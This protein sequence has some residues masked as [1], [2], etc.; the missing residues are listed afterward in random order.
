[1]GVDASEVPR[2]YFQVVPFGNTSAAQVLT[3]RKVK[4]AVSRIRTI[5]ITTFFALRG[6]WG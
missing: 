1:M 5:R 6:P 3:V 2:R 4:A